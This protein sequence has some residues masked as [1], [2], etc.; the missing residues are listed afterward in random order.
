VINIASWFGI[1]FRKN[2][3]RFYLALF[4]TFSTLSVIY[5]QINFELLDFKKLQYDEGTL[6]T[7]FDWRLKAP[8]ADNR[9]LIV[10]IDE[11]SL[12]HFSDI[13]GRWPWPR[14]VFAEVLAGLSSYDPRSI[15][16]NIM[17]SDPDRQDPDSDVLFDSIIEEVDN[18]IFPATRLSAHNDSSSQVLVSQLPFAEFID[19]DQT[20]AIL[21]TLFKG[22]EEKMG[23]NNLDIDDDGIVRR[24]SPL[25]REENY[26]LKTIPALIGEFESK[27]L[28]TGEHLINWPDS[29]S[30][31][32]SVSFKDL[33]I[34]LEKNDESVLNELTGRH[35]ILGL[36]APGLSFQRPTPTSPFTEDSRIL[37]AIADNIINDNGLKTIPPAVVLILSILVFGVL[38]LC[39]VYE[40]SGELIDTVFFGLE[41]TSIL[42][43]IGSISYSN[44]AIDLSYLILMGL[45]YFGICKAYDIPVKSSERAHRVFFNDQAWR[46]Y[47][48][49]SVMIIETG[50][51]RLLSQSLGLQSRADERLFLIDNFLSSDSLFQ[52]EIVDTEVMIYLHEDL[53]E[54]PQDSFILSGE[55]N[56]SVTE[57]IRKHALRVIID[58]YQKVLQQTANE[59]QA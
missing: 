46:R 15:T 59:Y 43:T 12:A 18:V 24:Y 39:H 58:S 30:E 27:T 37:A 34:A 25:F 35:L 21:V 33:Y 54:E 50:K 17:F 4:L 3:T 19:K 51:A 2:R 16:F 11:A 14:Y 5:Y 48:H 44:Y 29:M 22:A 6:D 31:Y 36:T 23:L 38:S 42:I 53:I 56:V 57:D 52:E 20:I 7:A 26:S 1:T 13:H 10:E 49:F 41:V 40:T 9:F 55:Y 28:V 32:A 45:I 47:K 8:P